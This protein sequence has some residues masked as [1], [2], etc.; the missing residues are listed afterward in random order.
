MNAYAVDAGIRSKVLTPIYQ[1]PDIIAARNA[2]MSGLHAG[3]I[4]L[5]KS[6]YLLHAAKYTG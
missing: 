2:Y 5:S 3:L 6:C 4:G 1:L